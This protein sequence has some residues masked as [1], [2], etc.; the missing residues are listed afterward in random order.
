MAAPGRRGDHRYGYH[1]V[2]HGFILVG[3]GLGLLLDCCD[4]A[5][6]LPEPQAALS[7]PALLGALRNGFA[8]V[9]LP[10]PF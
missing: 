5:T 8:L 3:N 10:S 2:L 4:V 1:E 9:G 7:A 6:P